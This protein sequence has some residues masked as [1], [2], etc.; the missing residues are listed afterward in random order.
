MNGNLSVDKGMFPGKLVSPFFLSLVRR[1]FRHL[2]RGRPDER[3][4]KKRTEAILSTSMQY[5]RISHCQAISTDEVKEKKKISL[6]MSRQKKHNLFEL[7]RQRKSSLIE[8]G[9][10]KR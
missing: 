4:R 9:S 7:T 8:Q 10:E 3:A 2:V 5:L 6:M 1:F